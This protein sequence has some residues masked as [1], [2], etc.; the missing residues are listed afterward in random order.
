MLCLYSL[1]L[2]DDIAYVESRE[3]FHATAGRPRESKEYSSHIESQQMQSVKYCRRTAKWKE[4]ETLD[5]SSNDIK[6]I[7][8]TLL[9]APKLRN[10]L[11]NDNDI[12]TIENLSSMSNL[13]TLSIANNSIK[14][15]NELHTKVGN[16]LYLNMSQNGIQSCEGFSK[17]YSLES[18]DLSCN[19]IFDMKE[20]QHLGRLLNLNNLALTG[21]PL[22]GF[23]DYRV[24]VL[25]YFDEQAKD[26]VLDNEKPTQP[27]LDKVNVL[28]ALRIVREGKVPDLKINLSLSVLTLMQNLVLATCQD[29]VF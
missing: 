6:Q 24:K 14:R 12:T 26:L 7:D 13:S 17:M 25:E 3:A 28:K 11:L 27:E 9:L 10:L 16:I 1:D 15:I 4:L 8:S 21:N 23:V 22:A 20:I 19:K 18:L 29:E 5:L 2:F